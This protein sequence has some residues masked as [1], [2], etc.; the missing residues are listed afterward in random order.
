MIITT[1]NM[2]KPYYRFNQYKMQHLQ[3]QP[4][5]PS[6][7]DCEN[8]INEYMNLTPQENNEVT[9][10][11]RAI[12]TR[13]DASKYAID[14]YSNCVAQITRNLDIEPYRP[15]KSIEDTYGMTAAQII[16]SW[17]IRMVEPLKSKNA[18]T[19]FTIWDFIYDA[20]I[21]M[22]ERVF[23]Q[24][25]S[26]DELLIRVKYMFAMMARGAIAEELSLPK[27]A[28]YAASYNMT[29]SRATA[30]LEPYDIDFVITN[31]Y[32][33]K[34]YVSVK[35]GYAGSVLKLKHKRYTLNHMKPDYYLSVDC[36]G[37]NAI[38]REFDDNT[39]TVSLEKKLW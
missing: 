14:D 1:P 20:N 7:D 26:T 24:I 11:S 12:W 34:K 19:S 31:K 10:L 3:S 22:S 23:G 35:S 8:I 15:F 39:K 2:N 4:E 18:S 36:N 30:D 33:N 5:I 17:F 27:F 9:K 21:R 32:G 38:L 13:T 25:L 29:V 6:I 28:K 16:Q 37:C